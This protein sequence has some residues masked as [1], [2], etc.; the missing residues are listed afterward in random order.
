TA[1]LKQEAQRLMEDY[2][3]ER[4]QRLELA[5]TRKPVQGQSRPNP[6]LVPSAVECSA[7]APLTIKPIEELD[8]EVQRLSRDLD[9]KLILVYYQNR[10]WNEFLDRYLDCLHAEPQSEVVETWA[11]CA[12]ESSQNSGRADEIMDR[13]EHLARSC[14]QSKTARKVKT[15]LEEWRALCPNPG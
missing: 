11:W 8:R 12:L 15:T 2:M 7:A 14:P 9:H 5:E 4:H 13:L 10:L 6:E 1:V 3:L